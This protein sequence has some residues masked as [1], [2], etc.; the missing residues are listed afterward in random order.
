MEIAV[1]SIGNVYVA[2]TANNRI[3]KFDSNGKLITKWGTEG[4][5]QGQF[6]R[7]KGSVDDNGNV[8][9]ADTGDNRIQYSAQHNH[10]LR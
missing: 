1:D 4:S 6:K 3:Q 10:L 2:D 7:P 8:Y 9:V 5:G